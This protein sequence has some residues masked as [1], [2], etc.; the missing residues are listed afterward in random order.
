MNIGDKVLFTF[1]D[2]L[3]RMLKSTNPRASRTIQGEV[4]EVLDNG[5]VKVKFNGIVSLVKQEDLT[6]L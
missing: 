5:L 4:I 3:Y 1:P 2:T 6:V